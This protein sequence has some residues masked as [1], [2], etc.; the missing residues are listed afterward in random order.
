MSKTLFI[1]VSMA[2][3]I[4]SPDNIEQSVIANDDSV[5]SLTLSP[6]MVNADSTAGSQTNSLSSAIPGCAYGPIGG[7]PR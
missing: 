6:I 5:A 4:S 3:A 1:K 7:P 2:L